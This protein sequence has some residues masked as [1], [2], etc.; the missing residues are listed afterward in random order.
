[1]ET[2]Q[3]RCESSID[4]SSNTT[5]PDHWS[6]CYF[7]FH[8]IL[9]RLVKLDRHPYIQGKN[10]FRTL[11]WMFKHQPRRGLGKL[12]LLSLLGYHE[13]F[14]PAWSTP[15]LEGFVDRKG[16]VRDG[17]ISTTGSGSVGGV[18]SRRYVYISSLFVF[19]APPQ[20]RLF[21]GGLETVRTS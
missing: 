20:P 1:M 16:A 3:S 8:D 17:T 11:I 14:C 18:I 13:P 2:N 19:L 12:P 4:T 21:S 5:E 10:S 15:P 9:K 6:A 7:Y